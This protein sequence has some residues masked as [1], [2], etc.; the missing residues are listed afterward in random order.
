MEDPIRFEAIHAL[1][2]DILNA[3]ESFSVSVDKDDED[4]ALSEIDVKAGLIQFL[5]GCDD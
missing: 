2:R 5:T 1:A 4:A 3:V